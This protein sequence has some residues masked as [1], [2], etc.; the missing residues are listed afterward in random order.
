VDELELLSLDGV[1]LLLLD[2]GV[3]L[4]EDDGLA[5]DDGLLVSDDEEDEDGLVLEPLALEPELGVDGV[6]LLEPE[7]ELLGLELLGLE[8]I[9]LELEPLGLDLLGLVD[10]P[11]L[12]VD[13]PGALAPRFASGPLL[14]PYRL[15]T[16]TAIGRTTTAVFFR[17]LI[18]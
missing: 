11:E 14:Q 9:E 4:D 2:D 12:E 1:A 17:I 5:L 3:L 6:V 15:V 13:E 8:P 16:A 18:D 10:E 7:A